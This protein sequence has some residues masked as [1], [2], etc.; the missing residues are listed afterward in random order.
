MAG[1]SRT[2]GR[3]VISKVSAILLTVAENSRCT[4]TEIAARSELPLSTTH[5]LVAE[6]A[7]W[8]VLERTKDGRFR[9]GPPVRTISGACR[10]GSGDAV[11]SIRERAAP[12]MEDLFRVTGAQVRMGYLDGTRVA[13]VE[14]SSAHVPVSEVCPARLPAHATALGKALLAFTSPRAAAPVL[15]GDLQQ[16][17]P[18]TVT[19]PDRLRLELRTVRATRLALCDGELEP[20]RSAVA[21]PVLGPAGDLVIALELR[22]R[23]LARDVPAWRPA[24]EVAARA[25]SRE[26]SRHRDRV[27]P[28]PVRFVSRSIEQT[29]E[30][31][32]LTDAGPRR[33][34]SA[35]GSPC[36]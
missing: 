19:H 9:A 26:L 36:R 12:V 2:P 23:D 4:L 8:G 31:R 28:Q 33:A 17:T 14:K 5:R 21:M 29:R 11:A 3:S 15:A 32:P 6:L 24:L 18:R 22:V 13:Y 25:L 1:N 20:Q 7:A 34:D 10:C 27:A 35:A 30:V 16:Y